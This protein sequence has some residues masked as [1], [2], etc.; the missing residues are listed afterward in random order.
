MD[1]PDINLLPKKLCKFSK[2]YLKWRKGQN[3]FN[4]DAGDKRF[5]DCLIGKFGEFKLWEKWPTLL[6][7]PDY[8]KYTVPRF[9]ADLPALKNDCLLHVKMCS[10][11]E[12]NYS[13][14][15]M[16]AKGDPITKMEALPGVDGEVNIL[17]FG[18]VT[19]PWKI[20]WAG[21][22]YVNEMFNHDKNICYYNL[23]RSAFFRERK[24]G[25]WPYNDTLLEGRIPGT[26]QPRKVKIHGIIENK[27]LHPINELQD[28]LKEIP[29]PS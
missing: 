8:A 19:E 22:C 1:I 11:V 9:G 5:L 12:M 21:W 25:V 4:N 24:F 6:E 17:V 23:T 27:V 13:A 16:V 29:C 26:M 20:K 15:W 18:Y 2:D 14:G 10:W 7:E 28:I 3:E